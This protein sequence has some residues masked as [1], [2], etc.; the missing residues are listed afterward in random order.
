MKDHL[1]ERSSGN[2]KW[3]DGCLKVHVTHLHNL[4]VRLYYSNVFHMLFAERGLRSKQSAS[5]DYICSAAEK[6]RSPGCCPRCQVASLRPVLGYP[7]GS[8]WSGGGGGRH[9]VHI[10]TR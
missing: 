7:D 9:T 3:M 4:A 2:K 8:A 5:A 10:S 6:T 1:S